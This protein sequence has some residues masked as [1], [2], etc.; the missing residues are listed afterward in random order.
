MGNWQTL[1]LKRQPFTKLRV[2]TYKKGM[3]KTMQNIHR[4]LHNTIHLFDYLNVI[5]CRI[6]VLN[7]TQT[8]H[9]NR[10]KPYT[11]T[12]TETC[13]TLHWNQ[14]KTYTD[15]V[16]TLHKNYTRKPTPQPYILF[17]EHESNEWNEWTRMNRAE[18]TW[19]T[20]RTFRH[21]YKPTLHFPFKIGSGSATD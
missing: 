15:A 19:R 11:E 5:R 7:P 12:G 20:K 6:C 8:L 18:R 14:Q 16:K 3:Q 13:K 17:F 2:Y 9:W 1:W 4:T 21:S 10:H